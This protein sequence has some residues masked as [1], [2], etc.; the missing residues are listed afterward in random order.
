MNFRLP[1]T[2]IIATSGCASMD[3]MATA[4]KGLPV[5]Q[6]TFQGDTWSVTHDPKGQRMAVTTSAGRA[7]VDGFTWGLTS[8]PG[9]VYRD[10]GQ[11][12]L[13]QHK[14]KCRAVG[15]TVVLDPTYEVA[16]IC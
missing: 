15:A 11:A 10:V 6:V 2:L 14:M 5:E 1:L 13:D 7:A 12:Y 16:Y 8:A 4:Y 9:T 3:Y